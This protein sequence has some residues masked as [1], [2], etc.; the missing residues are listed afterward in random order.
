MMQKKRVLIVFI[1]LFFTLQSYA[2][3]YAA[4]FLTTGVGARAL[5]M[6]GA[7]VAVA[8]DASATYWNPA[9]M[10]QLG[11]AELMLMHATRFSGLLQTD[12]ANFV[13]P[14]KKYVIGFNYIRMG[15][16]NIPYSSTLDLNGRP[17]IDK[18]VSDY[19]EAGFFSIG[20]RLSEN[21]SVGANIKTLRQSVGENSSLGFG[22]DVGFMYHWREKWTF[23]ANL[24]DITG[25]Y[26]YWDTGHRDAKAPGAQ[27]GA[28][29]RNSYTF[30]RSSLLLSVQHNIRFEG[31]AVSSQLNL[32]ETANGDF[33]AGIEY[34]LFDRL[35]FR[36]GG[37]AN[38]L[39]MGAG[40]AIKML[41]LDYAFMSYD[42][43]NAH[44]VSASFQF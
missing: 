20:T 2:G 32:G 12:M 5:G 25:T 43:G 19:E 40:L 14:G 13:Y 17:V 34:T 29:Y 7:F 37:Y 27:F 42:L 6:G 28:S 9:G 22:F 35:S 10:T 15:I 1:F 33:H 11:N 38:D 21:F 24:Q 23:G 26:V 8:D 16:D 44:R 3:K 41:K 39:T 36:F 4:E 30:L 31:Q 18:Y